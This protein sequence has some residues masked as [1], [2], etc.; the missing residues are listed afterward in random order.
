VDG[1]GALRDG[2]LF[3]DDAGDLGDLRFRELGSGAER[4]ERPPL[5]HLREPAP[6]RVGHED[7]RGVRA[8]VDAGTDHGDRRA[9]FSGGCHDGAR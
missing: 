6:A 9:I 1:A 5:E 8:D 7:P 3:L 4:G 2:P